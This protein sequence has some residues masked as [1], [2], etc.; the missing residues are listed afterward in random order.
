ML[1]HFK[2]FFNN[3]NQIVNEQ[4]YFWSSLNTENG[5]QIDAI[6]PI[7]ENLRASILTKI[8]DMTQTWEEI[9]NSRFYNSTLENE[10]SRGQ[11]DTIDLEEEVSK[12]LK[13]FKTVREFYSWTFWQM[14]VY[15]N[16]TLQ[17][18]PYTGFDD[19]DLEEYLNGAAMIINID[20]WINQADDMNI[21]IEK[22]K[23]FAFKEF[24]MK[25]ELALRGIFI[26]TTMSIST[27]GTK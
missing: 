3:F 5:N 16:N 15:R 21:D 20:L 25:E 14:D 13:P 7:L 9:A 19:I 24:C 18:Y 17:D 10:L 23:I 12:I 2:R 26:K 6:L 1:K 27:Q 11:N 8:N 22:I 4:L